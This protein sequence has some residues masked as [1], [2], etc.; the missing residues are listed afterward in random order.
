MGKLEPS[1]A[2][3]LAAK[4]QSSQLPDDASRAAF[5]AEHKDSVRAIVDLRQL[6]IDAELMTPLPNLGAIVHFGDGY[7]NIDVDAARRLGIGVSNTPDAVIDPVADTAVGLMLMT[8]RRFGAADRYV[9]AGRWPVDGRY[10]LTRD[11]NGTQVGIL[12]LGRIGS[13]IAARLTAFD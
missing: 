10:P 2:G 9:R 6:V 7:D 8:M 3:A 1:L 5:L 4:Y 11:V 13:A 12:G